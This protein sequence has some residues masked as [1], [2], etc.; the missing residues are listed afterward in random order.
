M[1]IA[2]DIG[3][4]VFSD[5]G[6]VSI[7]SENEMVMDVGRR[8][9]EKLSAAGYSVL[10]V[11]PQHAV[12][13]TDSLRQRVDAANRG[14]AQLFVSIHM[15]A[16]GGS[17]TEVWIGSEKGRRIAEKVTSSIA[18]MGFKNRGVKVQG[19]DG[20]RLYVLRHTTMTAILV[21]GCFVDSKTDMALY[22]A[23][24]M[25]FSIWRGIL[26]GINS[27][28]GRPLLKRGSNYK[29]DVKYLQCFLGIDDDGI[30]GPATEKAVRELQEKSGIS[31]DGIVGQETWSRILI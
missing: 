12:S 19:I 7:G 3:H 15:N 18:E 29:S 4:N 22:D 25:A 13:L 26:T 27:I 31:V 14:G 9:A 2:V 10:R 5:N 1:K 21:E 24:M 11:N 6:A 23:E 20:K 28:K 30:F 16:G 17:G 8:L